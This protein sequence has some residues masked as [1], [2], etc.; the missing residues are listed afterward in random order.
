MKGLNI[1]QMMKQAKQ[2]QEDLARQ[3]E[4]LASKNFES[5]VGG[6][7]VTAIVNGKFELVDLKIEKSVVDPNDVDMLRDLIV[8]AVNAAG[9][10]AQEAAQGLLGG[11]FGG[12]GMPD[13]GGLL[14]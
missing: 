5:S 2:M 4:L 10:Q 1:Q 14:G 12:P 9:K 8:A 6:G 11:V 7:M 13:L 3:Q